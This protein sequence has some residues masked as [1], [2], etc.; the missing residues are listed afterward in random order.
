[1]H[2]TNAR[3]PTIVQNANKKN[4]LSVKKVIH[5]VSI[6]SLSLSVINAEYYQFNILNK[7]FK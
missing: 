2:S 7:L 6:Y 3:Y 1:M 4:V 5:N